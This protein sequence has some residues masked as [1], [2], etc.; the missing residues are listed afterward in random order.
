MSSNTKCDCRSH[1]PAICSTRARSCPCCT[2]SVEVVHL[3]CCT[4]HKDCI[5]VKHSCICVSVHARD[6]VRECKSQNHSCICNSKY[7]PSC[8]SLSHVCICYRIAK[9][10][11]PQGLTYCY[12]MKENH[13][14]VCTVNPKKCN[15]YSYCG[16]HECVCV[17]YGPDECRA[18][19]HQKFVAIKRAVS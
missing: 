8:R 12:A 1:G 3:C 16:G 18:Y 10:N 9:D 17:K 7:S 11:D 15:S 5:A 4:K 13:K 14:C 2:K 19:A 6:Q